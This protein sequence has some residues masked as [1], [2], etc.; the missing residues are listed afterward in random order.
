MSPAPPLRLTGMEA[1]EVVVSHAGVE[2][3]AWPVWLDGRPARESLDE[4]ASCCLQARRLGY[5]V[6]VRGRRARWVSS[7]LSIE[8]LGEPEPGEEAGV[9]EVV[10]P[11]DPVA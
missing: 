11:D 8:V 4:I 5:D 2:V 7:M 1:V 3:A 6:A 10:V 9:E